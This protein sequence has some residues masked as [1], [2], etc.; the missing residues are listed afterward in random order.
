VPKREPSLYLDQPLRTSKRRELNAAHPQPTTT[1]YVDSRNYTSKWQRA[2][3]AGN[4]SLSLLDA[5][6]LLSRQR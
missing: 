6:S 2:R 3:V 4:H 1:L 5:D